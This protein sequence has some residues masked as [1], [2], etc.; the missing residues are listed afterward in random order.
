MRALRFLPLLLGLAALPAVVL[1]AAAHNLAFTDT[2]VVFKTDGTYQVDLRVDLD[3][4]ALGVS[5]EVPSEE[6]AAELRALPP[7]QLEGRVEKLR[8]SF[9]RKVRVIFDEQ[10]VDPL[11][12]FPERGTPLAEQAEIPTVLGLVARLE[13]RIPKDS[14]SFEFRA[15]LAFAPVQ[16]TVLDQ[17]TAAGM[18]TV[19]ERGGSS[20]PIPLGGKLEPVDRLTVAGRYLILGFWHILPEGLDHILF[21]L[22]LFLLSSRLAPLLWQV[23]AFTLAHTVTLALSTFGLIQLSPA[24]VEPLIALS[25]AYVAVENTLVSEMKPWRPAVVFLFGLLHGLGFAGVLS[26]LGLPEG[27]YLTALL[28]FNAGVELGQLAV[29]LLA[30]LVLGAFRDR[31]WYRKRVVVPLSAAIAAVGLFW[32]VQR[33]LG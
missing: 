20:G 12:S 1:P 7:E 10:P 24:I 22:G 16:L 11:V 4:L 19:L 9:R 32:A 25:I 15:S 5:S 30:L 13:G 29:I 8:E 17:G 3:A 6:V 31:P 2:L 23:S 26:E 18:H 28:T 21:V 27:E 14:R 33:T